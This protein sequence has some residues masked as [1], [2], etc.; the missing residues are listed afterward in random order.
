MSMICDIT[1]VVDDSPG[2]IFS[3]HKYD[4]GTCRLQCTNTETLS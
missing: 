2:L 4:V 1:N 3:V